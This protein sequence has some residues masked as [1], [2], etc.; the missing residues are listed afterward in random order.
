MFR[1]PGPYQLCR[2]ALSDPSRRL[3]CLPADA[4]AQ[5]ARFPYLH[6]P[7]KHQRG[8]RPF[9]DFA[10]EDSHDA[11]IKEWIAQSYDPERLKT[12][13]DRRG[14]SETYAGIFSRYADPQSLS[15]VVS[16]NDPLRPCVGQAL[17]AATSPSNASHEGEAGLSTGSPLTIAPGVLLW[18]EYFSKPA[19]DALLNAVLERVAQAPF[20]RPVMPGTGKAFS[21]E[22][23]NFGAL[24]WVAD[25]SGYRYQADASGDRRVLCR[26]FPPV[27]LT[28]WN[29]IGTAAAP[30][31]PQCCLVNLYR[32]GARMGLHQDRDEAALE[33]P[34]VSV[35]LGDSARFRI[36]GVTK[37]GPT[38]S[39]RLVSGDVVM[40]GGTARL[41]LSR[42]RPHPLPGTP[43]PWYPAAAASISLCGACR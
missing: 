2:R 18:R 8:L 37:G 31:Q 4:E 29:D 25:K 12:W 33:A 6:F 5:F 40:F 22:E 38:R 30:A 3:E 13:L 19:Q 39:M 36:G 34:V 27:L 41:G 42:H 32:A 11:P 10:R 28:L 35:S 1:W 26:I 21:V 20:Y 24:G 23:T 14:M 7:K 17:L 16:L 15:V 9:L 43:Q